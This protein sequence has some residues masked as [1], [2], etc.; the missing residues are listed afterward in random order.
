[1]VISDLD[2]EL[3]P[4]IPSVAATKVI[5]ATVPRRRQRGESIDNPYLNMMMYSE[6]GVG[7]TALAATADDVPEMR[8]VVLANVDYGEEVIKKSSKIDILDFNKY[9]DFND[10]YYFLQLHCD[11][12]D[13]NDT[14]KLRKLESD[15]MRVPL[16]EIV[17]P[18]KYQTVIFDTL[19]E[20]QKLLMYKQLGIDVMKTRVG[21]SFPK[22]SFEEWN[23]VLEQL[24]LHVRKYRN[25]PIHSIFLAQLDE[26]VDDKRK[27]YFLPLLQGQAQKLI[28]GFFDCVGFYTMKVDGEGTAKPSLQRR[29]YL[30]PVGPFKAKHRF[31]NFPGYCIDN[32][33]MKDILDARNGTYKNPISY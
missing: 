27:K 23:Q 19:S 33:T 10:L 4:T 14:V 9:D 29:L 7:K 24:L 16:A 12:R 25:M 18:R 20:M 21:E 22:P 17:T 26:D 15:F 5:P 30:S 28:H 6:F 3:A 11:L 2:S 31:G 8:D 1:M 13:R 32:P